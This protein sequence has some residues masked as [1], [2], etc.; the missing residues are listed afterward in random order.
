MSLFFTKL[1]NTLTD[2]TVWAEPNATRIVW[3]T[4]LSMA[5]RRGRIFASVPGLANRARVTVEEAETALERFMAPDKYSRTPDHE[6]RRIEPIEGGWR[7]LNFEKY[8]DQKDEVSVRES[9]RDYMRRVREKQAADKEAAATARVEKE[10]PRVEKKIPPVGSKNPQW[11]QA[12]AEAEAEAEK[13]K[14]TKER[15]SPK[16]KPPAA[17]A[18]VKTLGEKELV[19]EGV[20][21]E[22][23]RDWLKIRR[24]KRAAHLTLTAW[25]AL[26]REAQ[27]VALTPAQAV[28]YAAAS[29]WR[30]FKAQW[31][32][33]DR[34]RDAQQRAAGPGGGRP[35]ETAFERARREKMA[36]WMGTSS[37]PMG[38][39][40]RTLE[41]HE[42]QEIEHERGED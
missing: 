36:G 11:T 39:S 37:R 13:Y 21:L 41:P 8:R 14:N 40:S 28:A 5:D 31:Y 27:E 6:G 7:L 22:V 35:G 17:S 29:E 9:K 4:L 32:R 34:D 20:M 3:I 24:D 16:E 33:N 12:E 38:T 23:A 18:P 26:K 30:G 25:Q 19:A 15:A 10:A 2:S 1:F 42:V